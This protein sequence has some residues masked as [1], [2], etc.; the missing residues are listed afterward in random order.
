METNPV[1]ATSDDGEFVGSDS[2]E[3][4]RR[5]VNVGAVTLTRE[6]LWFGRRGE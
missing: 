5:L 1:A 6:D 2:G 3:D 4:S